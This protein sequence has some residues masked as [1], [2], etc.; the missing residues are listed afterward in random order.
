MRGRSFGFIENGMSTG[1][2]EWASLGVRESWGGDGR[3]NVG[4]NRV[5]VREYWVG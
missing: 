4:I 5:V 3:E 2:W 1:V